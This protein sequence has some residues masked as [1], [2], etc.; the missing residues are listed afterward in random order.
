MSI[1]FVLA[2][3][4]ALVDFKCPLI[5]FL[6]DSLKVFKFFILCKIELIAS[7]ISLTEIGFDCSSIADLT[8]L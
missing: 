3:F 4:K 1:P 6:C 8:I 5:S 7:Q 2:R